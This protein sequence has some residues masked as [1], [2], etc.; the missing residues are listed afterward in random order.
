MISCL[1]IQSTSNNSVV[2][3]GVSKHSYN[4]M[5]HS[6]E[7]NTSNLYSTKCKIRTT[8]RFNFPIRSSCF[9][10]LIQY[11][12]SCA[13]PNILIKIF[14]HIKINIIGCPNQQQP[15]VQESLPSRN[16]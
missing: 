1:V 13:R 2:I 16:G 10:Y 3:Y 6:E 7:A 11:C 15:F 12:S 8:F 5:R 9:S 4:K 14:L